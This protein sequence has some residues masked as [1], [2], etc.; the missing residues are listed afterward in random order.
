MDC[1]CFST[2]VFRQAK[3]ESP[4]SGVPPDLQSGVK[5]CPNLFSLCGFAIR[6]KGGCFSF[7]WGDYKSPGFYRSNLF[8]GGLQIRRDA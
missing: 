1:S 4:P 6:S 3:T 5:K 8:Y 7:C 2:K